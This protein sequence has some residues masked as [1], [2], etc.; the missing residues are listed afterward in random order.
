[1]TYSL[2]TSRST[3]M[4]ERSAVAINSDRRVMVALAPIPEMAD[5]SSLW[6]TYE[7]SEEDDSL[8]ETDTYYL[9]EGDSAEDILRR[10]LFELQMRTE[11]T[12]HG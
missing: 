5:G 12:R 2:S 11:R 3:A 1:M 9:D 10:H 6:H 4:P 8:V 7:W